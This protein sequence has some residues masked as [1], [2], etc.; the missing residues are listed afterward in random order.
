M[1]AVIVVPVIAVVAILY[2]SP[3]AFFLPP[4]EAGDTVTTVTSA[5]MSEFNG[6]INNLVN[7]HIGC[8]TGQI[9]YVDFEGENADNFNDIVTVYM[10]KYGVGQTATVMNDTSKNNL[11]AVF[12]DM[13]SYTTRLLKL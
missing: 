13:C 3:F 6:N 11:K 2:N 8:D 4:L 7:T 1:I 10:V 5:Y 9:V 12:D